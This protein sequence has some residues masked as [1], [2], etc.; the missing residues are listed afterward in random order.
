MSILAFGLSTGEIL[1]SI[2]SIGLAINWIIEGKFHDKWQRIKELRYA[3]LFFLLIYLIHILWVF[4]A[5]DKDMAIKDL[6]L[7]LPLLC[8]P[9]VLGSSTIINKK[10]WHVIMSAFIMGLMVNSIVGYWKYF[11]L[12]FTDYRELSVFVSHIR[13]SL[14]I[15]IGVLL[16]LIT[17]LNQTDKRKFWLII[18][19]LSIGYFVRILESGTGYLSLLLAGFIFTWYWAV[20]LKQKRYFRIFIGTTII[21]ILLAVIGVN[22]AY[23][24]VTHVRDTTDLENLDYYTPNGGIYMH[25]VD[26]KLLDNGYYLW[27][28][29]CPPEVKKAW[30]ERSDIPF[31]GVDAKGQ[32]LYGTLYRYVTSK[33]LRKDYAGVM[34]LS[35]M[36]IKNIENGIVSSVPRKYGVTA[37]VK[38]IIYEVITFKENMDPNGHSMIQRMYYLEAGLNLFQENL[39]LGT[40]KGDE[41]PSYHDYYFNHNSLLKID[42][43][44]R[45]HNQF[46][47]FFVCFGIIGGIIILIGILYPLIVIKKHLFTLAFIGFAGLSFVTDDVLDTQAGVTF[48]AFF[49]CFFVFNTTKEHYYKSISS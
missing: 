19:L 47:S 28:N 18:P 44:L 3:P 11:N 46:L 43:Q 35:E 7:K 48:F 29:I 31:D 17:I 10:E 34:A 36:D 9:L 22:L 14:L 38:E 23:K 15:G 24:S 6:V 2:P 16:L 1:M 40:S 27:L 45:A 37:R 21:G 8:F 26:S 30:Q 49:Y 32:K 4:L 20:K 13:L 33:G 39:I 42:N 41:M 25:K 12:D 5:N